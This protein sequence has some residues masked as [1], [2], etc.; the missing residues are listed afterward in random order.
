MLLTEN[1]PLTYWQVTPLRETPYD[2]ADAPMEGKM[3]STFF[4][5]KDKNFIPHTY[6]CRHAYIAEARDQE[7]V[8]GFAPDWTTARNVLPMGSPR[9]DL[10]GFWFRPTRL[11]GWARC[12]IVA[13]AAG[14]ARLRLGV[15]GRAALFVNGVQAGWMAPTIRNA[16]QQVEIDAPLVAGTNEVSIWFDDLAERDAVVPVSL[17]W[18]SGP[19]AREGLPYAAPAAI[20]RAV[21]ASFA[22][23]HLTASHFD[24]GEVGLVLPV[25]FPQNTTIAVTVAGDFMSHESLSFEVAV[26]AGQTQVPLCRAADLPA[27]Y[28]HFNLVVT[29]GGFTARGV[30]GA[31]ISHRTA[32]GEAAATIADR[33]PE[34]LAWIADHAEED[35][36]RALACLETGRDS[37]V[38]RA[39]AFI[40][41]TLPTIEACYDCADFALVPLLWSRMRHG[42]RL[43]PALR[44]RIDAA[45]LAYRF[46]MDEPGNDVQWYFSE[47]HA[48]LFHTACYLAGQILPDATFRR[49]G[50]K[51]LDQ[52][53]VGR[54]RVRAW[55]DHFEA[56]EMAEF[57]SAPYFPIDLKGMT[58][59][60][61]LAPDADIR[62]RAGRAIVRLLTVVANSAHHGVITAAQGRSYE[63]TLCAS[64]TLELSGIARLFWGKGSVGSRVHCL[65]QLAV[66]LRDFGLEVPD[67][68]SIASWDREDAQEWVFWQ[69]ENAFCRLYHYKTRETAMGSAVKYRW[70]DWGYQETLVHAR[71]GRN[72][73]A[74]VWINHPGEVI[75][76]GYGRP[77]FWGGSA[78]VPR[79]Q[80]Y[81]DLV[82]VMFQGQS[83]QPDFTHAWFPV[84]QFDDWAV[85]A[86]R[87]SARSGRGLL[88]IR[89]SGALEQIT[90]GPSAGNELR[91][92]GRDGLWVMRLGTGEDL[93]THA[94]RHD[95]TPTLHADGRIT[96]N[97]ADYG[98][99]EFHASGLVTAEDR[100]LDPME[101]H[102]SGQRTH[103]SL[104]SDPGQRSETVRQSAV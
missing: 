101:W 78:S 93:R 30:L 56:S 11:N 23:M 39:E 57:N 14:P 16:M 6:P 99:V 87:A 75:Q 51:G 15:C 44:D 31:E 38:A 58:A 86:D 66:C 42:D 5:T 88:A 77:S 3:D 80:Q 81:R 70:Y 104:S 29:C 61:A 102:L 41:R 4:L 69:G 7:P 22:A 65:P 67:L 34:T 35:T 96:I 55:F 84:A 90:R 83:P 72:P 36:V 21:E 62:D 103:I 8:P 2:V 85:D 47:N 52:S 49:S 26:D 97:D 1:T 91:L 53:A 50:R 60:F 76:S 20:V 63:H 27:D 25:P 37:D 95:L 46:W 12:V 18:L 64:D 48:L 68:T 54:D 13:E 79:V 74:Q 40:T 10:S 59:L 82:V 17:V 45:T 94:A 98:V 19:A 24:G 9:L 43:T 28:R 73:M 33:I 89:A 32:Q 92:A 71:I 100:V